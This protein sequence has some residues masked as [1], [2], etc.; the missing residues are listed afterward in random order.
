MT[1]LI[2]FFILYVGVE[3]IIEG[4]DKLFEISSIVSPEIAGSVAGISVFV[5]FLIARY[6][7]RVGEEIGSQSLLANSKE[8]FLDVLSSLIVLIAIALSYYE[9]PYIEGLVTIGIAIMILKVGLETVK[10]SVYSLMDVSPS[11]NIEK[12]IVKVIGS[13]SGVEG[14]GNLKLMSAGPFIF[15]ECEVM[16]RKFVD[17]DRAHEI[18]T[19][20]E[21]RVK[22][23][24][25][26]IDSFMIHIEPY[27]T[28]KMR[29]AIPVRE[30]AGKDSR[31]SP[32][33]GRPPTSP[34]SPL[35]RTRGWMTSKSSTMNS[36]RRRSGQVFL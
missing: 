27:E 28:E 9:I 29:I 13:V 8:S 24:V 6:Q 36:R 25:G 4:Y 26:R 19:E 32:R 34:W 7:K 17:I 16:V 3:F 2:S 21:S 14:Y 30:R 20:L 15:G 35:T 22:E 11:R 18:S 31:V 1:L 10:D 5:S 33:L 12:Q 23:E